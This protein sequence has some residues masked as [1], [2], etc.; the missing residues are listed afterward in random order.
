MISIVTESTIRHHSKVLCSF[1]PCNGERQDCSAVAAKTGLSNRLHAAKKKFSM[2]ET[3]S[4][5]TSIECYQVPLESVRQVLR[6][7]HFDL[8]ESDFVALLADIQPRFAADPE[9]L[10]LEIVRDGSRVAAAYFLRLSGNVATLGGL[11]AKRECESQAAVV[12]Q[13]FNHQLT[14]AGVAQIQALLDVNNA[15]SRMVMLN[16]PFRQVTTVRHLWFDLLQLSDQS[17]WPLS[18]QSC[19][20]ANLFSRAEMDALVEAT[21]AGSLD[22]PE[23]DGLRGP[24]EVVSGFLESQTWD[25]NLPWW[26]LCA[27]GKPIGCVLVNSHPQGIHEL[28]YVGLHPTWRGS[29]LGRE[30]VRFALR[31]CRKLGGTYF[32]TAVDT[33]NWP[34]CR[35][36]DSLGFTEIRELA[37]WLPK[38]E[39][40]QRHVAATRH[41]AV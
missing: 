5:N 32:T 1:R 6:W 2:R 38:V 13:E 33:R 14:Q 21:L 20:P 40:N 19:L 25:A 30:L 39:M 17:E 29:G 37:V 12:M 3:V 31:S 35:I 4:N 24:S 23:L 11:R 26:V 8:S 10:P 7:I 22:F 16:S 27:E 36:Y 18:P 41:R 15:S 34:A 28:T 9:L